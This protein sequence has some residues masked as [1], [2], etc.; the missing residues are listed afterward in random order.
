LGR[1]GKPVDE[2]LQKAR[3]FIQTI[4]KPSAHDNAIKRTESGDYYQFDWQKKS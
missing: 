2:A 1:M 4:R 3:D